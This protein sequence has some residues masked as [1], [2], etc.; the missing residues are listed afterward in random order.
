MPNSGENAGETGIPNSGSAAFAPFEA[1]SEWL[2]NNMGTMS[3]SPGSNGEE[4]AEAVPEGA[5]PSDPLISAMG[6]LSDNPMSNIIPIDWMEISKAL[7]TLHTRQMSDPQRTK[8]VATDYNR[9]LE[10]AM[11]KVWND[12]AS[13][14]W[15]LPRQ[16]QEEE[17]E[18]TGKPDKRFSDPEWESNPYYKMLKVMYLLTSEYI[19]KEAEETDDGQDP[20]EQRS[21]KFHLK[22][23]V[24]A[25]APVNFFHTNP[26]AIRRAVETRGMSLADGARNLA[27]DLEEGRLSM[28]DSEAFEVGENLAT[29]L[30]KVV[31]RNELIELIQYKPQTEQVYEVPILFLPPWINKY[32]ILDLSE[33]NSLV[34]YLVEHGFTVFM[35]S[36]KNP[37]S[38]MDETK[39]EDYMTLGPLKAVDVIREITGSENV[40]PVG[41][42]IG[43]TL[44]IVTLAWLAASDD[45]EEK[46]KFGNPTFMVSLQDYSE[47]GDTKVFIDKPQVEFMEMQMMER[48]YLD[49]RKMANMFN[50]LRS[51][52]LIWANVINNYLLGQK[53]PALDM[54]Y[55]NSDGTRLP[56]DAHSFYIRNTYLENNLI[57]P[58]KVEFMGRPIDLG[59]I[60]GDI[61][62]VGAEKDH[63]VPWKSAWKISKLANTNTTRFTLAA[64]GHI[65]GMIAPPE[66]GKGYWTG[67]DGQYE[68][69]DEWRESAEKHE[70]T[71][72]EDWRG[73]LEQRSGEQTDPPR[74]GSEQYRPIE[75]APGTYVRE[76]STETV[77]EAG[78]EGAQASSQVGQQGVEFAQEGA[79][80]AQRVITGV[81]IEGYDEMNVGEVV[82]RLDNLSAEELQRVR[83]YEQR[84]K[85]RGTLLKQIVRRINAAS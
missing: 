13:R 59:R 32:Y 44:L 64:S 71:W 68:T 30:G 9:R 74:V 61:Y 56:R 72:W 46:Q 29:T 82:E 76:T 75:D 84:N 39:F 60:T 8:Q 33:K 67:E 20:E 40:N 37:D 5:T 48:G 18:E 49:E 14:F 81:L 7:Q 77:R 22:Q 38:S 73:W 52:E 27:S 70:G 43:G 78:Q 24:D 55:W 12:A 83:A 1:W 62:A 79:R 2:R 54:L 80:A 66:K 58:G 16:E 19:L 36:W 4:E 69:A 3:A 57:K 85:N 53:P 63:I 45:E 6:K 65:A 23:F 41:Y 31:Y 51:C 34:K 26:A 21:L 28:V 10:E 17:E 42:C 11:V 47:V 25:I 35:I 15:G 50:L